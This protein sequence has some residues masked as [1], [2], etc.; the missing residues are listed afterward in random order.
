V[1]IPFAL[2]VWAI[3]LLM[4]TERMP[5]AVQQ[6]LPIVLV[7]MLS[8]GVPVLVAYLMGETGWR[9]LARR[10]PESP[11]YRGTWTRIPAA[12]IATVSVH[13]PL[14]QRLKLQFASALSV[15][16]ESDT[17]HL[18]M[19]GSHWPVVGWFL[20]PISLPLSAIARVTAYEAPGWI[21]NRTPGVLIQAT[22]DPNY[23]G[24]FLELEVPSDEAGNPAVF[25]QLPAPLLPQL[26]ESVLRP[27][28]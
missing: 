7:I 11:P 4:S 22:Y 24:E 3:G 15:G 20:P 10:F 6:A 9:A 18:A 23:T 1:V 27:D 16:V 28:R 2:L 19:L 13:D 12:A 21:A 17:L 25:I 14:Y 26:A 5:P 8:V